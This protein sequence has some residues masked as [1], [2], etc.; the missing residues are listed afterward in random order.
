M[1]LKI[2][3]QKSWKNKT[4]QIKWHESCKCVCRLDPITCNNKQKRN[5]DKCR[6]EC[7]VDGKC[8]NNFV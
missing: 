4:K 3:L 8:D 5:K 2:L 6:F 7:L 1:L